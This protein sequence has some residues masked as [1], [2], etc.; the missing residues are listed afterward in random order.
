MKR[1]TQMIRIAEPLPGDDGPYEYRGCFDDAM[2]TSS[3]DE[4]HF[5]HARWYDPTVGKWLNEDPVGFAGGASNLYCY[6]GNA[7]PLDAAD[8]SQS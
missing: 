4:L 8:P 5:D 1:K 7:P 6:V 2:F 3:I